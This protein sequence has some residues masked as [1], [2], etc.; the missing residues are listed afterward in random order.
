M[1]LPGDAPLTL[2]RGDTR[3][4]TVTFTDDDDVALD[5]SGR[6]WVAQIKDD[7]DRT[8][9]AVATITVDDTDADSGTLVLTLPAGEAAALGNDG[10]T[11]YWDLQSDDSGVVQTWLAGKVK[12]KGDVSV[13]TDDV[14]A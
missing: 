11:L 4:W 3:V 1:A 8:N 10:T 13:G 5:L 2:Y 6:V 12:V 14:V 7:K 9:A